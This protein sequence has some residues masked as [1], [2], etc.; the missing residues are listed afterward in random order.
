MIYICENNFLTNNQNVTL[1]ITVKKHLPWFFNEKDN[2]FYH[3][4]VFDSKPKSTF[5]DLLQPIQEKLNKD[6]YQADFFMILNTKKHEKILNYSDN[7]FK[8]NYFIKCIYHLNSS[9]A[10][11]EVSFNNKI[12]H[13][14]NRGI[15]FDNQIKHCEYTPVKDKYSLLLQVL[16]KK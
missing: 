4:L 1:N 10:Y 8:E 7:I 5:Y 9:D 11:S 3:N 14:Q 15:Y 12:E 13:V 2:I 16:F 6:I